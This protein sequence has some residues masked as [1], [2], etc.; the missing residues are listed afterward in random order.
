MLFCRKL[1]AGTMGWRN[2][3]F[4]FFFFAPK[5]GKI[6]ITRGLQRFIAVSPG[7]EKTENGLNVFHAVQ[8]LV[9]KRRNG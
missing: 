5:C 8:R 4:P 9:I 2:K 6:N 1:E 7:A 3:S